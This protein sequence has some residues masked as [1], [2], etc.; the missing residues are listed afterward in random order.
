MDSITHEPPGNQERTEYIMKN[1]IETA[2]NTHVPGKY[3]LRESELNFLY[4]NYRY[5]LFGL[6]SFVFKLGFARGQKA[7]REG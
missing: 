1:L 3:D 5:D 4:D 6:I 7:K 2:K